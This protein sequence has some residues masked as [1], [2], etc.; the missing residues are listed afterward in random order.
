MDNQHVVLVVKDP[1]DEDAAC[2]RCPRCWRITS[3]LV[4]DQTVGC[5]H[6]MEGE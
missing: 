3:E 6:C 5:E 1:V 2:V 4:L